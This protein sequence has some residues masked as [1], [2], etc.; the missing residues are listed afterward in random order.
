MNIV[1]QKV[2]TIYLAGGMRSNWQD[3]AQA[4]F[5]QEHKYDG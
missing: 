4:E 2:L 1:A 3:V 5:C